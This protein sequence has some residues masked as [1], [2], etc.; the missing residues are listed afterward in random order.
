M[1]FSSL[2]LTALISSGAFTTHAQSTN[3]L[4]FP[5]SGFS[6]APLESKPG[7]TPQLILTM[8]LPS[9]NGFAPNVNVLTQP[10]D[11]TIEEYVSLSLGQ[12]KSMDFQLVKQTQPKAG[13]ATLEYT[14][15][16]QGHDLHWYAK[17]VK[18]ANH[19]YLITATAPADRWDE[20]SSRLIACVDSFQCDN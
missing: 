9:V 18:S 2:F 15:I 13:I 14:G 19:I 4:H 10:Y 1:K 7:R 8:S 12:F 20:L 3:L 6:I 16:S 11:G 5:A 17:A